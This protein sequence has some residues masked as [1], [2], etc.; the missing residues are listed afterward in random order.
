MI[1]V[2]EEEFGCRDG[3]RW[4]PDASMI[5]YWQL[6]ASEIGVFNMINNT[7]S[8]YSQIVPVQYP[9]VGQ[10]PSSAKIGLVDA[11]SGKTEWIKLE[12]SAIQ[13]YVP[14]IQWISNDQ[15]LIQQINR[16]QNH[17]KVW[18][19][20]PSTKSTNLLY[21]E[22]EDS[23]VDIQYPDR[24]GSNWGNNDL[25]LVDDGKS[26]LRLTEDDW[27][28]AYTINLSSGKT[29]LVSSGNYD[30]ASVAGKTSKL[31]YYHASPDNPSQR[32][33]YSVD[34]GGKKK[35]ERLT[36]SEFSGINTYN[37]SPNGKYA[38]HS[39]SSVLKP[40]SVR[41]I[42]LP[43]H[44]TTRTIIDNKSYEEKLKALDLPTVEFFQVKTEDGILVDGRIIKPTDFDESSKYPIIFHVYGEP[45]GSAIH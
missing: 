8:V 5:A 37:I 16:K 3:F 7:D 14:A 42:S 39:H 44:K 18:L 12:G 27:R 43:D 13:N 1:G 17:L 25:A 19:H 34:L 6:D 41:L 9:K 31:L 30:V 28:N 29:T 2:Y 4:S 10:D 26:V 15:L 22:K 45:W 32:Y 23:W 38:F 11:T 33:L 21:E 40:T 20:Q 24:S 36:P 35:D